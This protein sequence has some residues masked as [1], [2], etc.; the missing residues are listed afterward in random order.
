MKMPRYHFSW[1]KTHP[2]VVEVD[3]CAYGSSPAAIT[4]A[5]QGRRNGREVALVTNSC[6]IGGMTSSGLG[7]TDLGHADGVGGIAREFYRRVGR[8]YDVDEDWEFEPKVAKEVFEQMLR[9]AEIEPYMREFPNRVVRE[10]NRIREIH[11]ES[12]LI[13]RA[14]YLIDASYEGDLMAMADVSYTVG[15]EGNDRYGELLNGVQVRETHQF[16]APVDPYV[17]E[18]KASSGLLPG[19][20]PEPLA[21]SGSE[22]RKI[23]AYNFRLCLTQDPAR[24][25]FSKPDGYDPL[26]YELLGRY[27]ERGWKGLFRKFD[28]IRNDK[29]DTNNHGA[30]STDFIGGNWDFPEASYQRR[31][32]IFQAH[33][34]WQKGWLWFLCSDPRVPPELQ[35]RI[36]SWGLAADEFE[37]T[38]GWPP[39]LYIREAR[40]LVSDYV[41]CEMHCR[42]YRQI[43]DSVG[44]GS[45]AMD[46]HNCQRVVVNGNVRNEGDVQVAGSPPYQI[47]YRSIRPRTGEAENLLIPVCVS[48]SHIAYGSIRMEP[49]FMILGQS[50]AIAAEIALEDGNCSVQEIPTSRLREKLAEAGQVT[51]SEL[52]EEGC[53]VWESVLV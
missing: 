20:S 10:G 44:L 17:I 47:P 36:R 42:G 13:V 9:E 27:F 18:G 32:E 24:I 30:V 31:E 51:E 34:R 39:Q 2:R 7:H 49:V 25:R 43:D 26:D 3:L 38:G 14:A 5:I 1:E 16:E 6:R 46:S 21:P 11:F 50:A 33:I 19:I 29:T 48:A 53:P 52:D 41:V 28:R 8:C 4:A 35:A 12:G 37:E 15:R 23:Q 22:D 40:R 45:Y